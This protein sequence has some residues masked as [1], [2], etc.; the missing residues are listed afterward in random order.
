MPDNN[1]LHSLLQHSSAKGSK[2]TA[3]Q[4]LAW[5]IGL[6]LTSSL[7]VF[8]IKAP[9]WIAKIFIAL[10]VIMIILYIG[11][12]LYFM[13]KNPDALRSES[14]TLKKMEIQKG[15]Q[16]DNITGISNESIEIEQN[17]IENYTEEGR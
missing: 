8:Y 10:C 7:G 4:P 16:G 14:F 2:S 5:I 13:L 1:L 17:Y 3:M 12:Y 9:E 6:L 11:A 15:I